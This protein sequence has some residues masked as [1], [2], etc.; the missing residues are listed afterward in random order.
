[1]MKN[2]SIQYVFDETE[3]LVILLFC[4]SV[5]VFVVVVV[6]IWVFGFCHLEMC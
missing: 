1:M 4:L 3:E 2:L 5:R 6:G